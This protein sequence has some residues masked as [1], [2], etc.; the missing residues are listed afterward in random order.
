MPG[1]GIWTEPSFVGLS[2]LS[3]Q[4]RV[5][6]S[7]GRGATVAGD[8]A[9]PRWQLYKFFQWVTGKCSGVAPWYGVWA[10]PHDQPHMGSGGAAECRRADRCSGSSAASALATAEVRL[11]EHKAAS[12]GPA[13]PSI[14]PFWLSTSRLRSNFVASEPPGTEDRGQQL[15]YPG[16]VG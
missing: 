3:C 14:L 13:G 2:Q 5:W 1:R 15:S 11:D 9:P 10:P 7:W 8:V 6:L 16:N 4:R 12:F